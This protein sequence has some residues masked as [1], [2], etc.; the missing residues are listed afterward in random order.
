[1][2]F[3]VYRVGGFIAGI[4][5]ACFRN[6]FLQGIDGSFR[7]VEGYGKLVRIGVPAG[8]AGAGLARGAFDDGLAHAAVAEHLE[9]FGFDGG[10]SG[11][12]FGG[13]LDHAVG[14]SSGRRGQ[15]AEQRY[16]R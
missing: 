14:L 7:R 4:V 6:G 9:G 3:G 15:D 2:Q 11:D 5:V 8:L 13:F 1:V 16:G 10:G 12:R